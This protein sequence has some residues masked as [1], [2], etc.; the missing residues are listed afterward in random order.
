MDISG[1]RARPQWWVTSLVYSAS[2]PSLSHGLW[3]VAVLEEGWCKL[4]IAVGRDGRLEWYS[5][6][7]EARDSHCH[8]SQ[9]TQPSTRTPT[10]LQN[11]RLSSAF[12]S[13]QDHKGLNLLKKEARG[14]KT[15]WNPAQSGSSLNGHFVFFIVERITAGTQIHQGPVK[16]GL[17]S[18]QLIL[19]QRGGRVSTCC[20]VENPP[21]AAVGRFDP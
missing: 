16:A 8:W 1:H 7:T 2:V 20:T 15:I 3:E 9:G 17:S 21:T 4:L 14:L 11:S 13:T 19:E 6:E 18:V 5:F 10:R 12:K